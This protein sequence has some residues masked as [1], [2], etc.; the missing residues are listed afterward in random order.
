M[1]GRWPL[2]EQLPRVWLCVCAH[3]L[4]QHERLAPHACVLCLC[5]SYRRDDSSEENRELMEGSAREVC[6]KTFG[7]DFKGQAVYNGV[8]TTPSLTV[9]GTNQSFL[10]ANAYT[11]GY[12]RN[13]TEEDVKFS[14]R[15]LV[16]GKMIEKRLFPHESAIGK[17]L[18]NPDFKTAIAKVGVEPRGTTLAEGA[19]TLKAS[20]EM[21]KKVP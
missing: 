16:V 7:H 12:G 2:R 17:V 3:G 10:T 1:S 14:R 19:T 21:W 11:L 5:P 6:L 4:A 9:A 15:V 13:I 8:K 18:Q 20:F